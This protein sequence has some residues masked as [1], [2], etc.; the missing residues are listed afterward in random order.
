MDLGGLGKLIASKGAK[1]LGGVVPGGG[2]VVDLVKGAFGADD[3]DDL[4]ARIAK[5]PEAE[6]K[7][8]E[9]ELTHR[10]D[11][12]KIAL[13][14]EQA[15]LADVQNARS[16]EVAIAQVTGGRDWTLYAL[17][18]T[19]VVGFFV[20]MVVLMVR[21]L[22]PGA[23]GYVNQLFGAL[24][25]GFGGVLSYFFGSSKGSADKTKMMQK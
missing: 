24:A 12:E 14:M 16:R 1:L 7:L 21:P 2:L 5:D 13:Q 4:V 15:R 9:L 8:R 25:A 19:V 3:D 11:L 6:L 18:W 17:A 22:P 23:A 20:L 10:T